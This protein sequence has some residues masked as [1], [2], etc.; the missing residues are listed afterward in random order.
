MNSRRKAFASSRWGEAAASSAASAM[1]GATCV[2]GRLV[3]ISEGF[4]ARA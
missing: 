1:N 3:D 4:S 2:S